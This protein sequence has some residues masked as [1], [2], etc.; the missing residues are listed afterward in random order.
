[1]YVGIHHRFDSTAG[2]ELGTAV[3]RWAIEADRRG[4]AAG[5]TSE[6]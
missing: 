5:A 6:E 1:M 2:R 4:G 3:A